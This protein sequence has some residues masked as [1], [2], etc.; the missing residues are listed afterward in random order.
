MRKYQNFL[1]LIPAFLLANCF[2]GS[3]TAIEEI[4]KKSVSIC[5]IN[6]KAPFR[7]INSSGKIM[8]EIKISSANGE[9]AGSKKCY[10]SGAKNLD[11]ELG[12]DLRSFFT[13][14]YYKLPNGLFFGHLTPLS[15]RNTLIILDVDKAGNW[16]VYGTCKKNGADCPNATN[17]NE[18]LNLSQE[19]KYQTP[20]YTLEVVK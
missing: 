13:R 3:K 10:L 20:N 8:G 5:P 17:A 14:T 7:V 1:L 19:I 16:R 18:L 2:S 12:V 9:V 11:G 15:D 4:T 6:S